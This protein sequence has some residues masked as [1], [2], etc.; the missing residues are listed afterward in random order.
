ML[1]CKGK[2][3]ISGLVIV[4]GELMAGPIWAAEPV[5]AVSSA[6]VRILA[7]LDDTTTIQFIDEPLGSTIDFLKDFHAIPIQIDE[8]ALEDKGI[9]TDEPVYKQLAGISL[10]SAL[11]LML[12]DL[13]LDW[14]I[15]NEVLLITTPEV[16]QTTMFTR[17]YDVG[18]LILVRDG[19]GKVWRD[20]DSMIDVLTSTIE[21]ETW[22]GVGGPGRIAPFEVRGAAGLVIRH[23]PKVHHQIGFVLRDMSGLAAKAGEDEYPTR[24]P[25]PPAT[26]SGGMAASGK[27]APAGK[28]TESPVPK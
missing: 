17:V 11:N 24:E 12:R 22:E 14:T 28:A 19:D 10:R 20:F 13:G 8:P 25:K 21:P 6:E 1:A 9:G 15:A 7:T 5:A 16:A 3:L 18:D 2:V 23:T 27:G 4:V 26:Y